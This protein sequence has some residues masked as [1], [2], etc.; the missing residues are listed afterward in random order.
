MEDKFGRD[1]YYLRLS[2][3][4]LC[5]LRCVYCM[6]EEGVEKRRHSEILSVEEI[7]E[8][9]IAAAHCGIRKVRVTGGEPL[10]RRGI[11]DICRRIA[12]IPQVEELC[13][14]TN[15]TLLTTYAAQLK[16]AGVSRLNISLDTLDPEKYAMITRGGRLADTLDGI[17]AAVKAG[18]R[19]IKIN[20]VLMGG[21][22]DAE[23]RALLELTRK[24]SVHVRFIELMPI[25]ECA[26]WS[27]ER[28]ISNS[29]VLEAAPELVDAGSAGVAKLYRLPGGSGTVGLISPISSHFCP[30]C[31]RIRVTADGKLKPC[32]H[33][34]DEVDL[35]GLHGQAL[36]DTIKNAV[37]IKP[38]RHHLDEDDKSGS[39]RNMNA[40]GG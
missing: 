36:I 26:G 30:T 4:D 37:V 17:D 24:E 8:I 34:A 20:A 31:N 40:I 3:T 1:I 16:E 38:R 12:A 2:V 33:S 23:I 21:I 32:L 7:E 6:P 13:M 39:V 11:V 22:N 35:R 15:G 28:F 25:G 9:V 14:T 18:F 19:N 10:V 27:H 5:N 29:S